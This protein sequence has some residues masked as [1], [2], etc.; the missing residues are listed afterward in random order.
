MQSEDHWPQ[1]TEEPPGDD[2]LQRMVIDAI[3]EATE[4]CS[5]EPDGVCEHGRPSWLLHLELV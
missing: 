4:G 5:V 3:V 1:P 2:E